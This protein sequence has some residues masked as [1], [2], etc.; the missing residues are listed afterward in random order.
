[1]VPL[2]PTQGSVGVRL[3][4]DPALPPSRR[5]YLISFSRYF[6][7]LFPLCPSSSNL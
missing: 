7:S 5:R 2:V 3:E 1:L 4:K 6:L